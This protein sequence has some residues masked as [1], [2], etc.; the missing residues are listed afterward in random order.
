MTS[1]KPKI[2]TEIKKDHFYFELLNGKA[3]L[4]KKPKIGREY[5]ELPKVAGGC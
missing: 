1:L 3:K 4:V 5:V 2:I